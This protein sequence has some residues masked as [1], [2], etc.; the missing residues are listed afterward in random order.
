MT[1]TTN[2][3]VPP[4]TRATFKKA[5]PPRLDDAFGAWAGR[6]LTYLQLPG[7]AVLQFDLS[8][9]TLQ[10]YRQM[11]D[12]YQIN[13]SLTVLAFMIH[14]ADW[15][16]ECED[17]RIRDFVENNMRETWTRLIRALSQAY[18]AGFSPV[19]LEYENTRNGIEIT[20][21][22]DLVPE[23]CTVNWKE[24]E[25]YAPPGHVRPKFRHYDGINQA[26]STWPIPA[27]N[28]LWYPLLMENG[29]YYGRKL[30]KPAFPSW[31]FSILMHLFANRYFERFGEPVPIG[32]ADFEMEVENGSGSLVSGREAM[33][34]ILTNLRNRSVVVLPSDR[35]T[36]TGVGGGQR[37]GDYLFDIEYLESQM[38]GADFERYL[39][40]L[41]EEMSLSLFTPTLLIRTADVGS[42]N[43]GVG[44]MQ[45]YLWMLN[46]LMADMKDYLDR[47]VC[48]RLVDFNFSPNAPRARWVPRKMGKENLE[49]FRAV[50]S[51]LIRQDKAGV[52]L[53]ELGEAVGLSLKEIRQI[54]EPL[55]DGAGAA[56][57]PT[58]PSDGDDTD[59]RTG[60]QRPS[61]SGP[62][63][64]NEP[65]ETTRRIAARIKEQVT[66]AFRTGTFGSDFHPSL[67]YR[68]RFEEA[69]KAEGADDRTAHTLAERFYTR[70][71]RWL[72]DAIELGPGEYDG[73]EDFQRMFERLL[74]SEVEALAR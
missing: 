23:E 2:L 49:I 7:G 9:L 45:M 19:A 39:F 67:G 72:D 18:W 74:D 60:R 26:A 3:W 56:E 29:D 44:H 66:K 8:R 31:F 71:E 33:Q 14:Q 34:E 69:L 48:D 6:D 63:G 59:E 46:A 12:H 13:A 54:R 58:S 11:R 35:H 15:H 27:E 62:R 1:D 57:D 41:D 70:I 32:R 64:V 22:K 51:E 36:T 16:I 47:Y 68:R 20:K 55:D 17:A 65:R 42:Y 24:V 21:F 28:T 38:R 4:S 37:Q 30:L 52:D 43:L 73:P 40:R 61:R 50:L 53:E 10:D 25:G 5:P